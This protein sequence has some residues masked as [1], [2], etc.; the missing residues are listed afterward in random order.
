MSGSS[1]PVV[2][3]DAVAIARFRAVMARRPGIADRLFTPSEREHAGRRSDPVPS[4][5]ARFA[6]KEATMKVLSQG[7][8][9][10]RFADIEVAPAS[11]TRP[12][13]ISLHGGAA[14]LARRQGIAATSLS[15]THTD[16]LAFAV[17]VG[18]AS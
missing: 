8:G 14:E 7:V 1:R 10:L 17:V 5:A 16:E 3:V 6:A 13:S 12:P 2:G 9:R 18:T 11:A 4:L 15:M